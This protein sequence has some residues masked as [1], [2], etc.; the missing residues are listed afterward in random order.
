[1]VTYHSNLSGHE[2]H[3]KVDFTV[4]PDTITGFKRNVYLLFRAMST[5]ELLLVC[6]GFNPRCVL[7]YDDVFVVLAC[8]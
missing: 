2:S 8:H 6:T 5:I 3:G 7:T 1:M 4:M